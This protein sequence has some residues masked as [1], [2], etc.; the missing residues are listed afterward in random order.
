MRALHWSE[1]DGT[2]LALERVDQ[3]ELVGCLI[4]VDRRATIQHKLTKASA[5]FWA[6]KDFFLNSVTPWRHKVVEFVKKVRTV[7]LSGSA[8]WTWSSDTSAAL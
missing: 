3:L 5:A 6:N 4:T 7:A 8:A 1:P 2:R